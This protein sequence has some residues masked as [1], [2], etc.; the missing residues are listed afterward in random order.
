MKIYTE[1]GFGNPTFISTEIE[2]GDIEWRVPGWKVEKI[3]EIYIRI[4]IGKKV[5]IMSSEDGIKI[6]NKNRNNFKTIMGFC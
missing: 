2:V 1:V 6:Q 3:K 5:L 4:W